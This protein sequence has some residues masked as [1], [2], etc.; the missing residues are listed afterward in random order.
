VISFLSH[1]LI[2]SASV[3]RG[4]DEREPWQ[5]PLGWGRLST[6]VRNYGDVLIADVPHALVR[7]ASR[8]FS[9][10]AFELV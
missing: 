2:A 4:N 9:T 6:P 8:L 5:P 10:L 7:A 1:K 3:P